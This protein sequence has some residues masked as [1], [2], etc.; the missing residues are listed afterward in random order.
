MNLIRFHFLLTLSEKKRY[1]YFIFITG[2]VVGGGVLGLL[3]SV[4]NI[5][6]TPH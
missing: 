1:F 6:T 2:V 3:R 5:L 4:P